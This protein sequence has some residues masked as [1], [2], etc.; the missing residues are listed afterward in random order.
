MFIFNIYTDHLNL[1]YI[2]DIHQLKTFQ[3]FFSL[4]KWRQIKHTILATLLRNIKYAKRG[5]KGKIIDNWMENIL[6]K[7]ITT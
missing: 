1:F 7:N 6:V 5:M 3:Y 2:K 4:W